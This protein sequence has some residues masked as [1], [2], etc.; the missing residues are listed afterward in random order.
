M[1]RSEQKRIVD[2]WRGRGE[3]AELVRSGLRSDG[4]RRA[5]AKPCGCT[6]GCCLKCRPKNHNGYYTDAEVQ[7]FWEAY[8][9]SPSAAAVERQFGIPIKGLKNIL[10][11]R[12]FQVRPPKIT[13]R[14]G[15]GVRLPE[16]TE[17]EISAAIAKLKFVNVPPEL[18]IQWKRWS[19]AKRQKFIQ[20]IRATLKP[21]TDRPTTPFSENVT[22]WEYGTPAAM[23]IAR[24]LNEGRT[25]QTKLVSIRAGS[26]GV[27]WDGQLW[28]WTGRA[29]DGAPYGYQGGRPRRLLH[30]VIWERTHGQPVPDKHIVSIKDG[31]WNNLSPDN[32]QLISMAE[33]ATR[34][35]NAGRAAKGEA[36]AALLLQRFNSGG[37]SVAAKLKRRK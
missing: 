12:G 25:S 5:K 35:K 8:Q 1:A 23:E 22:P 7:T 11:R 13:P 37:T 15:F 34:N 3:R 26:Q 28:F 29:T 14:L 30:R 36:A 20:R 9:T 27:I 2:L 16:P 18:K 21:K 4:K 10:E 31:N 17:A 32:F 6:S 19:M 24:K 33:N